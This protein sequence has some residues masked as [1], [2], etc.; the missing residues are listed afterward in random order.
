MQGCDAVITS[1]R[2][3]FGEALFTEFPSLLVVAR[4]GVGYDNIDVAAASR[5][6]IAVSIV[7]DGPTASTAEHTVAL[8]LAVG[9]R[10]REAEASLRAGE[11]DVF[12]VHD[13]LEFAGR[14]LGLVGY[15]RIGRRVGDVGLALG[16]RVLV[17]DP[18]FSE[19]AFGES[20]AVV[21]SDLESLLAEADVVSLHVPLG[22]STHHLLDARRIGMMKPGAILINTARGPLVD[23]AALE[24]ALRSGRL[25]GAGLDV[26]DPEPPDPQSSLLQLP[27]VVATPHVA[28]ATD[29]ARRRLWS[30]AINAVLAVF[31][32][33]RPEHLVNPDAWDSVAARLGAAGR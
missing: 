4:T 12:N 32:G 7:P 9:K 30:G 2:I 24:A 5:H 17:H 29:G 33:V 23:T 15:G 16:M 26:F 11:A 18:C 25:R 6:G 28:A 13:G 31:I 20:P 14:T 22:P 19:L 10:L 8:M 21:L 27:N 3:L 1:N